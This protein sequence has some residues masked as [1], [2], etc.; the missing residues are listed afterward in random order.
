MNASCTLSQSAYNHRR[1]VET[2]DSGTRTR[3]TCGFFV[4]PRMEYLYGLEGREIPNTRRRLSRFLTSK[5]PLLGIAQ[6]RKS[7]EGH[8][9]QKYF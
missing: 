4:P 6:F 7:I 1:G 3:K 9:G 8:H 2:S 5:P